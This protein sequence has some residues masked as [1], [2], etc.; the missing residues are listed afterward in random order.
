[1]TDPLDQSTIELYCVCD[2]E[3]CW[4][5][6]TVSIPVIDLDPTKPPPDTPCAQCR[7]GHHVASPGRPR[8]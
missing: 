4:C 6:E 2:D 8:A 3:W 5:I 1:M 7:E